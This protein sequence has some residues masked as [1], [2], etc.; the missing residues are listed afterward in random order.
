MHAKT[1]FALNKRPI[2]TKGF[3]LTE[4]MIAISVMVAISIA[5][6]QYYSYEHAKKQAVQAYHLGTVV[7]DNINEYFESNQAMPATGFNDFGANPSHTI[8]SIHYTLVDAPTHQSTITVTFSNNAHKSLASKTIT[9]LSSLSGAH[10]SWACSTQLSGGRFDGQP[11]PANGQALLLN[12]YC[13]V[14]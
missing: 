12:E 5:S 11:I 13:L 8:A 6:M 3:S 1:I 9:L 4:V 10:L 2:F 7:R 14:S